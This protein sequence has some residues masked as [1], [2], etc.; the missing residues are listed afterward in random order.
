MRD[1]GGWAVPNG[2]TRYCRF[3]RSGLLNG[4]RR[5]DLRKALSYGGGVTHC[6]DLRSA[7]EFYTAPDVLVGRRSVEYRC[8]S[9]YN[10]DLTGDASLADQMARGYRQMV[11]NAEAV[12]QI[13]SWF[14]RWSTDSDGVILYHCTGGIDR[15]GVVSLLLLGLA[16][17]SREDICREYLLSF[18]SPD[19]IERAFMSPDMEFERTPLN[20]RY[21][22]I[23]GV[24]DDLTVRYGSVYSYL[25]SCGLTER[26]LRAVRDFLVG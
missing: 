24:Y 9:L 16:R 10:A 5:G 23:A 25:L 15:S 6:L 13:F 21:D 19:G 18:A 7:D 4:L 20:D 22:L 3:V 26:Q 12:R 17:V 14:A 2:T 11:D 1:L 8:V